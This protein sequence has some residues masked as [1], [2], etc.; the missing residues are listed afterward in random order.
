MGLSVNSTCEHMTCLYVIVLLQRS[1]LEDT[2]LGFLS[3]YE[4]YAQI[5]GDAL[6]V[7]STS[8]LVCG[9]PDST[10]LKSEYLAT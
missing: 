3:I 6:C 1:F 2:D 7:E 4:S 5:E 8:L 10:R 9:Y